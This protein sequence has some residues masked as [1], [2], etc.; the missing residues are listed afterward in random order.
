MGGGGLSWTWYG[1]EQHPKSLPYRRHPVG[2]MKM[3]QDMASCPVGS[4]TAPGD[5][6]SSGVRFSY[7]IYAITSTKKLSLVI[8]TLS[9]TLPSPFSLTLL[10]SGFRCLGYVLFWRVYFFLSRRCRRQAAVAWGCILLSMRCSHSE[11]V[12]SWNGNARRDF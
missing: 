6:P 9:D 10:T 8:L 3:S 12:G 4:N 11:V 1:V 5:P 7:P 2:T